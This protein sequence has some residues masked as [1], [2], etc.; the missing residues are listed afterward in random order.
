MASKLSTGAPMKELV[1]LLTLL[2]TL[3][4]SKDAMQV[5]VVAV[6]AVTHDDQ[7]TRAVLDK[8]ILGAHGTTKQVESFNLDTVINGEHVLLACDDP[9]GCEAPAVGTYEGERKRGKWVRVS[10]PL[11]LSHKQVTRWYK[12]AGSW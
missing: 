4:W 7:G 12:I 9:K 6:H 10:F 1:A 2:T 5:Q 8:G 11:P 3:A